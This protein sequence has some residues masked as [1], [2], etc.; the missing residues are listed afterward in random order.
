MSEDGTAGDDDGNRADTVEAV[1][2]I[3]EAL[4]TVER[5]RGHLYS[6][7]QLTGTADFQLGEGVELLRKARH[8]E[9]ADRLEHDLVGRNVTPGHWTFQIIEEYDDAYWSV[10]R[11]FEKQARDTLTDGLRHLFEASLKEQRRTHGHPDH[12]AGPPPSRPR[13]P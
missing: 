1:G 2:K 10:F 5:A 3:T 4:E 11:D 13:R 12:D 8:H 9:L 6:F 7:H